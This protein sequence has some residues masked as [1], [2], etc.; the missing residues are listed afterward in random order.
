MIYLSAVP[1]SLQSLPVIAGAGVSVIPDST[2]LSLS[3][4]GEKEMIDENFLEN[5]R[6]KIRLRIY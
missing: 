5:F 1:Y 3:N 4:R 6:G 2:S